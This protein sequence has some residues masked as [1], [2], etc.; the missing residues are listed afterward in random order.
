MSHNHIFTLFLTDEFERYK[1]EYNKQSNF[2]DKVKSVK[3][4]LPNLLKNR[5]KTVE[6]NNDEISVLLNK[7]KD[8][9]NRLAK[10]VNDCF[11]NI[12]K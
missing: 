10:G 1:E 5:Y 8:A 2:Y 11:Q 7:E 6:Y 4:L 12:V 9:F 3:G